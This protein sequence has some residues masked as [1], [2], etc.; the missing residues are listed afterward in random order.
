MIVMKP[1]QIIEYQIVDPSS[2]VIVA[3]SSRTFDDAISSLERYKPMLQERG[4]T[5]VKIEKVVKHRALKERLTG[6][7]THK[8]YGYEV[9]SRES[10]AICHLTNKGFQCNK[11]SEENT[12]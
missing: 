6:D 3:P 2:P 4:H 9:A 5:S 8:V 1:K 7:K 11:Y 12:I 10:V